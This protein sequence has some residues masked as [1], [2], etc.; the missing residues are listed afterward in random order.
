MSASASS[1][2]S[3]A[4][5]RALCAVLP[6]GAII[7]FGLDDRVLGCV[8]EMALLRRKAAICSALRASDASS[9]LSVAADAPDAILPSE[10]CSI[11]CEYVEAESCDER[12]FV[13]RLSGEKGF[14]VE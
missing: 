8:S 12:S 11:V 5:P 1:A 6:D 14:T 9:G 2:A 3:A 7:R 4:R 10:I 13:E